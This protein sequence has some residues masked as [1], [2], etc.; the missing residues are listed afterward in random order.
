MRGRL[1]WVYNRKELSLRITLHAG[2]VY[3]YTNPVTQLPA[4]TSTHVIRAARLEPITPPGRVY[5]S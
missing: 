4:C 1:P 5:A 3:A 2:P